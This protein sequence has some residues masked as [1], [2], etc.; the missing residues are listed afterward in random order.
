MSSRED[1]LIELI[2]LQKELGL[3]THESERE[4]ERC[5]RQDYTDYAD[6]ESKLR[7][8]NELERELNIG[9]RSIFNKM[10]NES[11]GYRLACKHLP[12][13]DKKSLLR[14]KLTFEEYVKATQGVS[15]L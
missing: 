4:L 10:L 14:T 6:R 15:L 12:D 13:D 8:V 3:D 11:I 1:K 5:R 2:R 9:G 7:R